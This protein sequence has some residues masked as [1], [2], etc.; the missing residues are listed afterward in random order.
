MLQSMNVLGLKEAADHAAAAYT[1]SFLS[2][3]GRSHD[4]NS[5]NFFVFFSDTNKN[6]DIFYQF[7]PIPQKIA[8]FVAPPQKIA[9]SLAPPLKIVVILVPPHKVTIYVNIHF[10]FIAEFFSSI[11]CRQVSLHISLRSVLRS[12]KRPLVVNGQCN[13]L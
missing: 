3:R 11:V 5:S 10:F 4:S 7:L 12:H 8:I 2:S 1:A 13:I 9:I 6:I